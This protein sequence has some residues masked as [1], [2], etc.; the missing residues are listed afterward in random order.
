M[1]ELKNVTVQHSFQIPGEASREMGSAPIVKVQTI[2]ESNREQQWMRDEMERKKQRK[3]EQAALIAANTPPESVA[4]ADM[5]ITDSS[6]QVAEQAKY[7][8]MWEFQQY[9]EVAPGE[10]AAHKFLA[11]SKMAR[12]SE[13]IDF[14]AGTGRGALMLAIMGMKVHMLDFADN[15]L[16]EEVR[17]CL[18]TQAHVLSFGVHD[19]TKPIQDSAEYGYCTD[20]MEHIPPEYVPRVLVNILRSARHVFFQISCTE[21]HCGALINEPLHL[22]VHP[23][24]WWHQM[25]QE[26]GCAIH[27][28]EDLG[29][30]CCFY[31]SAW[32]T[33]KDMVDAGVLNS[34][35]EQ[36]RE[37]VT[38]NTGKQMLIGYG[39]EGE[40]ITDEFQWQ[41][42]SPHMTNM[43]E[44]MILGS[45]P[46]L[47]KSK[48]LIFELQARGV[49]IITLNGAYN[50][51][52]EQ[53]IGPCN[54]VVVDARPF[55]ARF[56]HTDYERTYEDKFFIASQC[57]PSV[58]QGLPRDRTYLWHTTADS[59]KDILDD[60]Y[61]NGVWWGIP[62]GSTVLLRAIPMF[63]MLGFQRFHLIGCDSCCMDDQHH[64]IAQ[65]E[66]DSP[67]ACNVIVGGRKFTCHPDQ[68]SQ[69]QEFIDL[70]KVL[71]DE[72]ELEV[73]GE[74]LL[75]WIL[76]YGASQQELYGQDLTPTASEQ[77]V[78]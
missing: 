41:Q 45:G 18:T 30:T 23:Y 44:V 14:G 73:H 12:G 72:I 21:D 25:F 65:P 50:W 69:A 76:K 32:I 64:A 35:M 31:V 47:A 6:R 39:S 9:R 37:N 10:S 22:S 66:N 17:Q 77:F 34:T 48:D 11:V 68:L 8:R 15:C 43:Q 20:V 51:C 61:Q 58:L 67:H 56:T 57:H 71:G 60:S 16:D 24:S 36:I 53:G 78:L 52:V 38:M 54:Q 59:I 27:W 1:Q 7:R 26:L 75:A 55:N 29:H 62:G 40:A 28:S 19:L 74:G 13:V 63:R 49:K 4:P 5:P 2:E 33:G 42:V 70:I 3:A 46:S